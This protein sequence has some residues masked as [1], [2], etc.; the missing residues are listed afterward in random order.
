MNKTNKPNAARS[1]TGK[2]GSIL[3]ALS[4]STQ[5]KG[6]V[7]AIRTPR[8][9]LPSH[10]GLGVPGTDPTPNDRRQSPDSNEEKVSGELDASTEHGEK[11]IRKWMQMKQPSIL[12]VKLAPFPGASLSASSPS[13]ETTEKQINH[14]TAL[15]LTTLS[16]NSRCFL[17]SAAK[18]VLSGTSSESVTDQ[19]N[20]PVMMRNIDERLW[21]DLM[22]HIGHLHA[23]ARKIE[24]GR[25][26]KSAANRSGRTKR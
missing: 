24:Q 22:S 3:T 6:S 11:Q 1:V 14:R 16:D 5:A 8:S 9:T 17:S 4:Q 20:A 26:P 12:S 7:E 18:N 21:I 13:Q 15:P 10:S 23:A 2:L 19:T 25:L